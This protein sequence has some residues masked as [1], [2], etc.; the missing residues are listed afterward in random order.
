VANELHYGRLGDLIIS[1]PS[2]VRASTVARI[3]MNKTVA[4]GNYLPN[5]HK[6]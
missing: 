6:C 2:G 3:S 5:N 4:M 1:S